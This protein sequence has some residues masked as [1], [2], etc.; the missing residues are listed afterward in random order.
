MQKGIKR[1]EAG[2]ILKKL[3]DCR[4]HLQKKNIY[5]C[6]LAFRDVLEKMRETR[7]LP[8]D[9]KQLQKEINVFQADLAASRSFHDLYGPVTFKD[10]DLETA[11]DFMKQLIQ[12]KEEEIL[13]AM[14]SPKVEGPGGDC[15]DAMQLRIDKIMIHVERE[16]ASATRD[17]AQQPTH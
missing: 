3:K 11:L 7:M 17:M 6:L 4:T 16:D 10:D 15:P 13:A 12:I 9:E 5:S 8:A 14:E 1:D 2:N